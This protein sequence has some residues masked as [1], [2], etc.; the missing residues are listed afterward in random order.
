VV[1]VFVHVHLCTLLPTYYPC[2][3]CQ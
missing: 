1:S 2:S 3:R